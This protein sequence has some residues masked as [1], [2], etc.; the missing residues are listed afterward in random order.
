MFNDL[1]GNNSTP[2]ANLPLKIHCIRDFPAYPVV[3]DLPAN[4]EN[5]GLI[6]GPETK[7][8]HTLG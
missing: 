4:A 6:P 5:M 1:S 2:P 3:K 7:I 8:P